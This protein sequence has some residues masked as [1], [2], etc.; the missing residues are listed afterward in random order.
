MLNIYAIF[1]NLVFKPT[2]TDGI[3]SKY[4]F[5]NGYGISVIKGPYLYGGDETYLI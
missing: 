2:K 4:I 1:E 5:S 3:Q